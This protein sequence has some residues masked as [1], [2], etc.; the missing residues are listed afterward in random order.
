[1]YVRVYILLTQTSSVLTKVLKFCT[2]TPYNH[3][4]LAFDERLEYT[5]SFGRLNPNDPL[6]GG[7]THERLDAGVFKDAVCQVFGLTVTESQYA[8]MRQ[9]VALMQANQQKYKFN[10]AGL[11]AAAL[12]VDLKREHAYFCSQF[13][14]ALLQEVGLFPEDL[15]PHL[16]KPTDI[17][18]YLDLQLEYE[19]GLQPYLESA[20]FRA[21][22]EEK[23]VVPL[24]RR[25][26]YLPFRV[27]F[28]PL[29]VAKMSTT[30][31]GV[32]A[33]AMHASRKYIAN[34]VLSDRKS[35]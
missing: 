5:Y 32:S 34:K 27:L 12:K 4:S 16:V 19:G 22:Y 10:F 17:A 30:T 9:R 29:K 18:T 35:S 28:V 33:R 1:M 13:V 24:R 21:L 14:S 3:V 8:K 31:L 6:I 15:P 23:T 2:R 7:F 26:F 25:L 11:F 20:G